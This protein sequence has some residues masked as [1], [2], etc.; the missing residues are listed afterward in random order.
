MIAWCRRALQKGSLGLRTTPI[1][2]SDADHLLG[3][4]LPAGLAAGQLLYA[5]GLVDDEGL[6]RDDAVA[7]KPD[8]G[9]HG[10]PWDA[11]VEGPDVLLHPALPHVLLQD[12]KDFGCLL[13]GEDL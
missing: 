3:R 13:L 2:G 5:V 4:E 1:P 12:L 11:V 8:Q 10:R 7:R 6:V 9:G